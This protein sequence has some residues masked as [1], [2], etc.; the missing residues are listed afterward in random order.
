MKRRL[1]PSA[2]LE[3]VERLDKTPEKAGGVQSVSRVSPVCLETALKGTETYYRTRRDRLD[4]QKGQPQEL[5]EPHWAKRLDRSRADETKRRW[6]SSL[7]SC[8]HQHK[9]RTAMIS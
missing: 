1:T 5:E 9:I 7:R 2:S 6:P 8:A 3:I 4:I